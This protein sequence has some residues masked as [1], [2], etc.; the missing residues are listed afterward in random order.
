MAWTLHLL[1]GITVIA[2]SAYKC[3]HAAYSADA[4]PLFRYDFGNVVRRGYRP[5]VMTQVYMPR[6]DFPVQNNRDMAEEMAQ[7]IAHLPLRR[8]D[9]AKVLNRRVNLNDNSQIVFP[10]RRSGQADD[11]GELMIPPRCHQIG[12]CDD[13]GNYPTDEVN[14]VISK[15]ENRDVFQN[16]KLDLPDVPDIT[17]RLGPQE[18]NIE[19]CNVNKTVVYPK[20]AMDSKGNWRVVLNSDDNPLQGFSVEICQPDL[21]PCSDIAIIQPA[22]EARCVQKFHYRKMAILHEGKMLEESLKVPSCCS[23]LAKSVIR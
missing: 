6:R 23:C 18:E 22:Y 8:A 14:D 21:G 13:V 20:A 7:L 15:I 2:T 4:D 12:I 10:G 3:K 9:D 11:S 5:D 1:V 16:D 17:Q 19:L